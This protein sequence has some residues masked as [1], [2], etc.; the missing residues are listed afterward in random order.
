MRR[1]VT[2]LPLAALVLLPAA[3]AAQ[4][5]P[6]DNSYRDP[7]PITPI[8]RV[9]PRAIADG[10]RLSDFRTAPFDFRGAFVV[11]ADIT[12]L[13]SLI[14]VGIAQ[15]LTSF[16]VATS[17]GGRLDD[18]KPG[19]TTG[20]VARSAFAERAVTLG[21]GAFAFGFGQQSLHYDAFDGL[22][23][24]DGALTLYFEHN[25]CCGPN[26][27]PGQPTDLQ[28]EFE[29]DL[30]EEKLAVDIDRNI[31]GFFLEFG[32]A[33]RVDLGVAIP[34]VKVDLR[35]RVN[36]RILRT[37]TAG[38]PAIHK[39]DALELAHRTTYASGH[40]KGIGDIV[41]RGKVGL[42]RTE[43]GGL[44]ASVNVQLPTGD[45]DELLGTGATRAEVRLIWSE[46][47]G[48]LGAHLN[49]GYT[50]STGE[51]SSELT[52]PGDPAFA[53][54]VRP[55]LDLSLPDEVTVVGG[56][57]Y[58]LAPRVGV[59]A[60]VIGRQLRDVWQFEAVSQTFPARG[61]GAAPAAF[62]ADGALR[63]LGLGSTTQLMTAIGLRVHLGKPLLLSA[64]VLLPL[65][66]DGLTPRAGAIVGFS[67][68]Y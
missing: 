62:V 63:S 34:I 46:Q 51:L 19:A 37:A 33:D 43:G 45:A 20:P 67:L 32:V 66:D 21:K 3:G 6:T 53:A 1:F 29:R 36:S 39:F 57:E 54:A 27:S 4:T 61:P 22:D 2:C 41:L 18:S 26:A 12:A 15:Q 13:P 50:Y 64:D 8:S 31:F 40:A 5:P 24:E 42:V 7:D 23:L 44:A 56:I 16:P 68:A 10:A 59:S 65:T 9:I 11:G 17:W 14:N 48:R 38:N 35:T 47:V 49:A 28:P 60:D 55:T 25:N 58:A 52:A 30:L